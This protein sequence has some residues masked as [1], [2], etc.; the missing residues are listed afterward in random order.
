MPRLRQ[1]TARCSKASPRNGL[2]VM[3]PAGRNSHRRPDYPKRL[4]TIA[5]SIV[6]VV[7]WRERNPASLSCSI[8]GGEQDDT[9]YLLSSQIGRRLLY[10][11]WILL[12]LACVSP[13]PKT[14]RSRSLF[15]SVGG[16]ANGRPG[17]R[18]GRAG[19]MGMGGVSGRH[20]I[21]SDWG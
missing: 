5:F 21:Y 16:V 17:A 19:A 18:N 1:R 4:R 20:K 12:C 7:G 9:D 10:K 8:L 11:Y 2:C 3:T 6:S 14:F 13:N 15:V